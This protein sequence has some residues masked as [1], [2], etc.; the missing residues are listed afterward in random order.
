MTDTYT[1]QDFNTPGWIDRDEYREYQGIK[2]A[3]IR[4][5]HENAEELAF[6]E[7]VAFLKTTGL[8]FEIWLYE[9]VAGYAGGEIYTLLPSFLILGTTF[10]GIREVQACP[11]ASPIPEIIIEQMQ[12]TL[13]LCKKRGWI[14]GA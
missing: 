10:D 1:L 13:D 3:H 14:E 11:D 6:G 4:A 5:L 7:S 9:V 12:F 8:S 2:V